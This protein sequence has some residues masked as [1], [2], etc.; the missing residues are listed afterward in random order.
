MFFKFFKINLLILFF[1][2]ICFA[3]VIE[4]IEVKGNDRV[5]KATIKVLGNFDIGQDL[6]NT[7]LN[8]ILKDLYSTDFFKDISVSF[9][10]NILL[11]TIVENPIIQSLV[12]T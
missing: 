10:N 5:S 3:E 1:S 11:I 12:L 2:T 6:D 4:K 9:D 8:K 7:D